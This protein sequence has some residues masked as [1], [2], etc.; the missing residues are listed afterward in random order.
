M[1]QR[2]ALCIAVLIV[3]A[4]T[5]TVNLQGVVSNKGGQSIANAIVT[6]VGQ[7]MI[8]STD[9]NG[10]FRFV[11]TAVNLPSV[12]PQTENI[13]MNNGILRFSLSN[14]SPLKVEVF[15]V[16]GKLLQKE[17]F[18]KTSAGVYSLDI[19]KTRPTTNLLIIKAAIGTHEMT[20]SYMPLNGGK[21]ILNATDAFAT[22]TEGLAK[23]AVIDDTIKVTADGFQTKKV[24]IT[25]YDNQNQNITLDSINQDF[26]YMGNPP[27]PSSGCG[28]ALSDLKTGTYSITS[29]GLSR[30]YVIDIP[31]NYDPN[32]PYRLIFAMHYMCGSMEMIRDSKFY[33]L[34]NHATNSNTPCIFVAPSAYS[35]NYST[36]ASNC[37]VWSQGVKD[38][39]FFDDMLKLFKEKLCVDTTRVFSCGF[40]FGAMYSYSLSLNHQK[41]LRAV[42]CWAPANFNIYQ[43]TN[44]HEPIGY[45]QT[46]GT[47]DG[48]CKW[49]S[50]DSRKE[51]GKYC[52][53]NHIE[54]NGCTV[55][56][57]IPL[58]TSS[59]H[60]STEFS[61][62]KE[63][64][65]VKFGSFVASHTDQNKDPGSSVN[66]LHKEAWDFFMKF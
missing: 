22:P 64:Y 46:T 50:S 61:G 66:W 23:L 29:A 19:A 15:D 45:Y 44:T 65:P 39:T 5:Q 10:K 21:Y 62:C 49:V 12:V 6:L 11:T 56:S 33:E 40:S 28:K 41:Q 35:T 8:D 34:K 26:H 54:D 38:H 25:S 1:H 17:V 58:A 37:T 13:S 20:F 14:P 63:A 36:V 9:T 32:K 2:I 51:G 18:S 27:G 30:R 24:A 7:N 31:A 59:T 52:L 16:K 3:S 60:V 47:K 57:N 53:L 42:A 55:P 48:T 4:S 43:P